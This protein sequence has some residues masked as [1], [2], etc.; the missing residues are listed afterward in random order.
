M[1]EAPTPGGRDVSGFSTPVEEDRVPRRLRRGHRVARRPTLRTLEATDVPAV[2]AVGCSDQPLVRRVN[3]EIRKQAPSGPAPFF[4]ECG[5]A[6]FH[7]VWLDAFD[8][9]RAVQR[10]NGV[11]LAAG[12]QLSEADA[13]V[14][15]ERSSETS[16]PLLGPGRVTADD[17][18]RVGSESGLVA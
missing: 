15:V 1:L 9:D 10:P 8:Y 13:P 12:H 18:L 14:R 11:L 16:F 4:C 3:D 6:C 7:A 17:L 2:V 5:D